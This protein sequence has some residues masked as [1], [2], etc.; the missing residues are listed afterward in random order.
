[1]RD[2]NE[3][4]PPDESEG[5]DD[6]AGV[7]SRGSLFQSSAGEPAPP[8][9]GRL[10]VLLIVAGVLVL[11]G[12]YLYRVQ[13]SVALTPPLPPEEPAEIPPPAE[14]PA[15]PRDATVRVP[16]GT[17]TMGATDGDEDERPIA[18]V[19]VGAFEIDLTE[20]TVGAY[21]ACVEAS[22]CSPPDDTGLYCNWGKPGRDRHPVNCVDWQ[23]A[24]AYCAFVGKR[25]P[26]EQE[27]EYAARGK[28]GR[29]FPWKEGPPA[30]QLCWNGDGNDLGKNKRQGTCAVGLYP[31]GASPLGALDM[32]GNVWEWT[33]KTYC[34]TYDDKGCADDKK[35]IRG[36]AWNNIKAEYVR[37]QDRS[38]EQ[39]KAQRDNVGFR[40]ARTT[41]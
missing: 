20:V 32:A 16:E 33:A 22:K 27:W 2:P 17:F 35:V 18:E 6:S 38:S 34:A 41:K 37:A 7:P 26:S 30:R 36:G 1:M 5:K 3:A 14:G 11:F 29:K 31:S 23:Q 39:V 24:S 28:D 25:L 8:G 21:R 12:I 4:G 15:L 10:V 40:C 19:H 9:R 13:R